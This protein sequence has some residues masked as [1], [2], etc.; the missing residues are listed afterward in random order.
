MS[1][2]SI[3]HSNVKTVEEAVAEIREVAQQDPELAAMPLASDG[4]RLWSLV[5]ILVEID[6][7][8]EIGIKLLNNYR[9]VI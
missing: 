9:G 2:E 7:G 1:K 6:K 4:T 3:T 8:S 5:Q